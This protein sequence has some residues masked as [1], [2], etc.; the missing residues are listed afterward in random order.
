MAPIPRCNQLHYREY[1]ETGDVADEN[2]TVTE[3]DGCLTFTHNSGMS[4]EARESEYVIYEWAFAYGSKVPLI[5]IMLRE[6][7]LH[8]RLAALQYLDF[9]NRRARP[10]DRLFSNVRQPKTFSR[11]YMMFV[12]LS[13]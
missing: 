10:W 5:P 3:K 2:I 12:V 6:T 13:Y 4:P 7:P 9:T 8:P 11:L 1:E